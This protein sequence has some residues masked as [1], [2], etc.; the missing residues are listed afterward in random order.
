MLEAIKCE[1]RVFVEWFLDLGI[2]KRCDLERHIVDSTDE[3]GS[4]VIVRGQYGVNVGVA[5]YDRNEGG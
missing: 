5:C 1:S 3:G 2:R 4:W